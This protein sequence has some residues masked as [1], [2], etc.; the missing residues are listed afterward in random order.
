MLDPSH[1]HG[2]SGAGVTLCEKFL[3]TAEP[4]ACFLSHPPLL[5]LLISAGAGGGKKWTGTTRSGLLSMS[6]PVK[7][8]AW[9]FQF[10]V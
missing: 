6:S 1:A 3:P 8:Y 10:T 7:K 5:Q 2:T 4:K 9:G